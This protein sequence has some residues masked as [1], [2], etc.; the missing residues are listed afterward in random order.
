[1]MRNKIFLFFVMATLISAGIQAQEKWSL[2]DCIQYATE[3][4]INIKSK[5]VEMELQNNN[6]TS[7]ISSF[8]PSVSAN[9]SQQWTIGRSI[10]PI[11]NTYQSTRNSYT[12]FGISMSVPLFSGMSNIN[13]LAISKLYYKASQEQVRM[14]VLETEQAVISAYFQILYDEEVIEIS[15][16]QVER[17]E[18]QVNR[19][20]KLHGMG[21]A[22]GSQVCEMQSQLA[23]DMMTLVE[24]EKNL[25]LSKLNLTQ[26]LELESSPNFQIV[27]IDYSGNA[28]SLQSQPDS[29]FAEIVRHHPMIK[30]EELRLSAAHKK[31]VLARNNMLPKL[32]FDMAYNNNCYIVKNYD[33]RSFI[34]Q[35]R[36][37]GS[38]YL[39]LNLSIPIFDRMETINRKREAKLKISQQ[40]LQVQNTKKSLYNA[41]EQL[42]CEMTMAERSLQYA[43]QAKEKS[44][45]VYNQT[46]VK[47]ENGKVSSNELNEAKNNF[48]K[49]SVSLS[50]TKYLYFFKI[51]ILNLFEK[52]INMY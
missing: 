24:A 40:E 31:L 18:Y 27:K 22:T 25:A 23:S 41:I 50:Q 29:L 17:D 47:Y 7:A 34:E 1:M 38:L 35:L 28:Q 9:I 37:N 2:D 44:E 42:Y 3:H 52:I 46:V 48:L 14:S 20:V 30:N 4:N 39:G 33:N 36:S 26:L 49:S 12:P 43:V 5:A 32:S 51:K 6:V 19:L 16:L 15:K 11:D 8:L 13:N 45:L 10:S 21:K